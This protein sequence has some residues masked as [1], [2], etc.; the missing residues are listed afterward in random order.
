MVNYNCFLE[1][2]D[3]YNYSNNSKYRCTYYMYSCFCI[4]Y[5]QSHEKL[6]YVV[7]HIRKHITVG[8][9]VL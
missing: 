8:L 1:S 4:E 3:T 7:I 5:S 6:L 9:H 2:K